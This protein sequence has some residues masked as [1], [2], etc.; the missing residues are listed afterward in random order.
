VKDHVERGLQMLAGL[1]AG[2]LDEFSEQVFVGGTEHVAV[3]A[4]RV[5]PD[6][7]ERI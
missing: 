3:D 1:L 7:M 2:R 6:G 4:V 5:E